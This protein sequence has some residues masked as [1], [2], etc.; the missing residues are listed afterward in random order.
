ML[1]WPIVSAACLLLATP[2]VTGPPKPVES[3]WLATASGGITVDG[4]P[5]GHDGALHY[6]MEFKLRKT[7]TKPL[8]VTVDFEN[9]VDRG[10]PLFAE[11]ELAPGATSF[12]VKSVPIHAIRNREKYL[13]KVWIF[14]DQKRRQLLG[15]HEQLVLFKMPSELLEQLGVTLL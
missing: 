6:E 13:V 10:A 12:R 7:V 2:A 9:P 5:K 1:R 14:A 3:E 8:F 11:I 15:T 4:D